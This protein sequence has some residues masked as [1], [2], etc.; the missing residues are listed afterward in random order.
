MA[1][2]LAGGGIASYTSYTGYN[3]QVR[4]TNSIVAGNAAAGDVDPDLA[5]PFNRVLSN[6]TDIFGSEVEGAAPSDLGNIPASLLFA[7]A[8]ADNGGPTQT[9]ALRDPS[10]ARRSAGTIRPLLPGSTAGVARPSPVGTAPDVG[11]FELGMSDPSPPTSP[12]PT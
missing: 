9:I 12:R 10:T 7:G 1:R 5:A 11:A 3:G 8:L 2:K 4:L 6:G